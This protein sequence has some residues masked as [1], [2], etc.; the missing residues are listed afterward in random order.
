M[1]FTQSQK[2]AVLKACADRSDLIRDLVK[3]EVAKA[4]EQMRD[5]D[6]TVITSLTT[7]YNDLQG[8]MM[9]LS[10]NGARM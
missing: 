8:A 7:E 4:S 3:N 10:M 5:I 6:M 2:D 1:D 9:Q